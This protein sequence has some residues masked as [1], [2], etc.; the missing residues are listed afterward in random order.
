[1]QHHWAKM[2]FEMTRLKSLVRKAQTSAY[3]E[4]RREECVPAG[5]PVQSPDADPPRQ[6]PLP[7]LK[8]LSK[9]SQQLPAG[10]RL[11]ATFQMENRQ[12]KSNTNP[13]L[14]GASAKSRH[15]RCGMPCQTAHESRPMRLFFSGAGGSK[16]RVE[17]DKESFSR[18]GVGGSL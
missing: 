18:G 5:T 4:G 14:C 12:T 8:Q 9:I 6:R 13:K 16:L 2:N 7:K 17:V 11:V 1:M 3:R 10:R 15:W